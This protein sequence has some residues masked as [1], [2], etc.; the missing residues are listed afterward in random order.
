MNISELKSTTFRNST[1]MTST[2]YIYRVGALVFL[3]YFRDFKNVPAGDF[4]IGNVI[5]LGFRPVKDLVIGERDGG[6]V[7]IFINANG[8]ISCYK[9]GSATTVMNAQF[10]ACW[11]TTDPLPN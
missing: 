5:P 10:S 7:S 3:T 2:A 8:T 6:L 9:Y 1:Y 11:I 4:D